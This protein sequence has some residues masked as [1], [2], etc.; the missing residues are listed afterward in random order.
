[1]DTI[2]LLKRSELFKELDDDALA[3]LGRFATKKTMLKKTLVMSVGDTSSA[4]Y[5]IK[6]G[7]V[8]VLI[9]NDDGRE[10]ILSTL[11]AGDHFGEL[12]LLDGEP[13]SVNV[14][15]QDKCEFIIIHQADFYALLKQHASVAISVIKYL[16]KRVRTITKTAEDLALLDAYD[17]LV[18]LLDNLASPEEQGKRMIADILTHNEIAVRIGSG[19]EMV[20]RMLRR[21]EKGQYITITDK[22]ITLNR[23]LPHHLPP[24]DKKTNSTPPK[25]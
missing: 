3:T 14:M 18:K 6:S 17:R 19:R 9:T 1:M 13:R 4:L 12:A 24:E 21:L 15:T 16:C 20:T 11:H 22:I 23:A 5:L 10:M 8:D 2:E 25:K 7:K